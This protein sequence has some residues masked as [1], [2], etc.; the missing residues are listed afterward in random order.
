VDEQRYHRISVEELDRLNVPYEGRDW[1]AEAK[2]G[3][4]V[5]TFFP[6]ENSRSGQFIIV[7]DKDS[8]EIIDATIWR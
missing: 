6:S 3:K 4:V 7:I 5:V 2:H 8:G 1:K